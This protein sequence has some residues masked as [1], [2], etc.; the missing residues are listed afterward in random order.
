[1]SFPTICRYLDR[2]MCLSG[3]GQ[4]CLM[5]CT[6]HFTK[7][8]LFVEYVLHNRALPVG[9]RQS[10]RSGVAPWWSWNTEQPAGGQTS[11]GTSCCTPDGPDH[12]TGRQ[13][14]DPSSVG[15]RRKR[16]TFKSQRSP[17]SELTFLYFIHL[18]AVKRG[19]NEEQT[20]SSVNIPEVF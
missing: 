12:G 6:L 1:M 17:V 8:G 5:Q 14:A 7:K 16:Q 13:S 20:S 4:K 15:Q 3:K 19:A 2:L 9:W 11:A 10:E 18:G